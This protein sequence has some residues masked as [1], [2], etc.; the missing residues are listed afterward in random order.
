MWSK[1]GKKCVIRVKGGEKR[2]D[3]KVAKNY[4][5]PKADWKTSTCRFKK[6]EPTAE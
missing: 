4:Q 2:V 6:F 1:G 5:L 3:E